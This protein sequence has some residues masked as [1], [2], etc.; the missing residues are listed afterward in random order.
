MRKFCTVLGHTTTACKDCWA[1]HKTKEER[2]AA[3]CF[4]RDEILKEE[5]ENI[6]TKGEYEIVGYCQKQLFLI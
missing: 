3:L 1:K 6:K 5:I 2:D 4:I